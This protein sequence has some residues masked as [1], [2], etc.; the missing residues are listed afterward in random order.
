VAGFALL[1]HR[2]PR[3]AIIYQNYL[4]RGLPLDGCGFLFF[5]LF[6]AIP[7][8]V[9]DPTQQMW[10]DDLGMTLMCWLAA[11]GSLGLVVAAAV[12]ASFVIRFEPGRLVI[13]RLFGSGSVDLGDILAA[14]PLLAG[15]I[16]AGL[17][18]ELRDHSRIKLPWDNLVNYQLLLTALSNAGV[19][20]QFTPRRA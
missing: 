20:V 3:E 9:C 11:A 10:G 2:G 4:G 19:E 13:S 5:S 8:W 15:G 6:F 18:L 1:R 16:D 14:T 7:L 12:N 17:I